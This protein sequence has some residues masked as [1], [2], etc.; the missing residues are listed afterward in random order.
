MHIE[1][2]S[3]RIFHDFVL[4]NKE[5]LLLERN[6][7][8]PRHPPLKQFLDPG[9]VL[10]HHHSQV[11]TSDPVGGACPPRTQIPVAAPHPAASR[12]ARFSAERGTVKSAAERNAGKGR[13]GARVCEP[14]SRERSKSARRHAKPAQRVTL[15][16][17]PLDSVAFSGRTA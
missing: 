8:T 2:C 10:S 6:V 13:G 15:V 17:T 12:G 14:A 7:M 3:Y 4:F 16:Q 5:F 11:M 9:S 1:T